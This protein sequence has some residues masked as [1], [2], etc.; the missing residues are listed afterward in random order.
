MNLKR[1][2]LLLSLVFMLC[3][4]ISAQVIGMR[5][6]PSDELSLRAD[7]IVRGRIKKVEKANYL[8]TYT[9]I[10]TLEVTDI[11]KG[12]SRL[13]EIKIW[14]GSQIINA[15]DS[16]TKNVDVLVFTV[17]E[18]TFYR[19]LNY[20]YGQFVIEAEILK[21]WREPKGPVSEPPPNGANPTL[22]QTNQQTIE[23]YN[24][25]DKS[26]LDVR[27][28]IE[29]SLRGLRSNEVGKKLLP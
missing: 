10:A 22:P 3:L 11:L 7:V 28:D 6:M 16:F 17:R 9:Q 25:I 1:I 24:I 12:D 20:Q 13:K 18:Q 23:S 5:V 19:L 29:N 26:Y 2:L 14:T 8:G 27:K 21:G 4:S 15:T